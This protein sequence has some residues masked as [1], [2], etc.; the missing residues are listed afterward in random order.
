MRTGGAFYSQLSTKIAEDRAYSRAFLVGQ[1][2]A[3]CT[4]QLPSASVAF[5]PDET[6]IKWYEAKDTGRCCF[7]LPAFLL[8]YLMG[9][10][11]AVAS[12]QSSQGIRIF[13]RRSVVCTYYIRI[14]FRFTV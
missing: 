5:A 10:K 2:P 8:G 6:C 9:I 3:L 4:A 14:L 13:S 11:D 1:S 12:G 7:H